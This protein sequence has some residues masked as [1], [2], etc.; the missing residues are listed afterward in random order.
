M[1]LHCNNDY[2]SGA[3]S[4]NTDHLIYS[5]QKP[6]VSTMWWKTSLL[7]ID[8]EIGIH[9]SI[10]HRW[11]IWG[12]HTHFRLLVQWSLYFPHYE[13]GNVELQILLTCDW[14]GGLLT[15]DSVPGRSPDLPMPG[16]GANLWSFSVSLSP[17]FQRRS[18]SP[19]EQ[20]SEPS[21]KAVGCTGG[22]L[23]VLGGSSKLIFADFQASGRDGEGRPGKWQFCK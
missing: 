20:E 7:L 1:G 6:F 22:S 21:L 11:H 23:P 14:L 10:A 16:K 5:F 12:Q 15:C 4:H 9:T 19:P 2:S 17:N 8:V 3:L 18:N 13:L